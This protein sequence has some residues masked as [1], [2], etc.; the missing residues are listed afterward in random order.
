V[1]ALTR[2]IAG[3]HL[4]ER[5]GGLGQIPGREIA[6]AGGGEQVKV[7]LPQRLAAPDRPLLVEVGGEQVAG[8][9]GDGP[10]DEGRVVRVAGL[11]RE[12]LEGGDVGADAAGR[13]QAQ[14]PPAERE[15]GIDRTGRVGRGEGA[16]G[17]VDGLVEL[18]AGRG[19]VQARPE[20]VQDLVA[21]ERVLGLQC[22][23]LDQAGGLAAR[24]GAFVELAPAKPDRES[25]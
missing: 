17:V 13:G 20:R 6:L 21:V 10:L 23:D 8:V 5:V 25:A 12:L 1:G 16:A 9:A 7:A 18:G 11:V 24:K 19:R 14:D 15:Q 3:Q 22:Q 2:R 4:A